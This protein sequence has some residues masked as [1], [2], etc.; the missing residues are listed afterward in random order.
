MSLSPRLFSSLLLLALTVA[1]LL[2]E[3]AFSSRLLDAAGGITDL[4]DLKQLER[5]GRALSGIALGLVLWA[6]LPHRTLVQTILGLIVSMAVAVPVMFQ[7]Q[8]KLVRSFVDDMDAGQRRDAV[9]LATAIGEAVSGH[10][11]I[12]GIALPDGAWQSPAGKAFAALFPIL[13]AHSPVSDKVEVLRPSV[14]RALTSC[15]DGHTCLGDPVS[16]ERRW[17]VEVRKVKDSYERYADGSAKF[18]EAV[19]QGR[20]R[21]DQEW[22]RYVV[23]LR[24]EARG[25]SPSQIPS[26]YWPK[27]REK[28]RA[29]GAEIP[30]NWRPDDRATFV[31][32]IIAKA[33]REAETQF[34][35]AV[36]KELG[37]T[38]APG[39]SFERFSA[40]PAVQKR[41]VAA[42]GFDLGY[43][44]PLSEDST[45]IRLKIYEVLLTRLIDDQID[46]LR[47]S[48]E[49]FGPGGRFEQRGEEAA[50]RLIVPPLALLFSL[51]GGLTHLTKSLYLVMKLTP[52][53]PW[54]RLAPLYVLPLGLLI[55]LRAVNPVTGS[56][57]YATL[58]QRVAEHSGASVAKALRFVIQAEGLVY[59]TNTFIRETVLFGQTFGFKG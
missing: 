7:V 22:N 46:S 6:L 32:P 43:E 1:Y 12:D 52:A 47:N 23:E 39:L 40:H 13:S 4:Q 20:A 55:G 44:V 56:A 15:D 41:I 35:A 2:T 59:P 24:R 16:F 45:I 10:L 33:R 27:I 53:P 38:I 50:E 28:V 49:E 19:A 36:V 26:R 30:N 25:R 34:N 29:R 51:I 21:A 58:D 48:A 11:V 31:R 3:L 8:D 5:W 54:L 42:L 9:I 57:V 37:V 18:S 17:R 14:R